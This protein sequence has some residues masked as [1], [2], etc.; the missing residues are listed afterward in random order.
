ME[1]IAI[2]A[3]GEFIEE[4]TYTEDGRNFRIYFKKL[5]GIS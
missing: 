3:R 2:F 5:W 4:N 1:K